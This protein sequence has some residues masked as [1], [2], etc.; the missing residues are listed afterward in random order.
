MKT[1]TYIDPF[2]FKKEIFKPR[3]LLLQENQICDTIYFINTGCIRTWFNQDGRDITLQFFF[4]NDEITSL[5][6]LLYSNPSS[7]NIE[8]V[9]QC[10]VYTLSR[11]NFFLSLEDSNTKQWFFETAIKKMIVHSN[12]LLSLLKNKPAERYKELLENHPHIVKRIPQHQ[13]ASYLGITSV[14]LSRIRNRYKG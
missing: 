7:F 10:E 14:S 9:E 11:V 1:N 2:F 5:E 12:R 3:T 4:E 13:I 8:T 6:S